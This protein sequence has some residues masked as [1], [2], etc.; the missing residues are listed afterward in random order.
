MRQSRTGFVVRNAHA[1]NATAQ[2]HHAP[3]WRRRGVIIGTLLGAI[4]VG[5]ARNGLAIAQFQ[6]GDLSIKFD[7]LWQNFTIGLLV[8]VAVT[9]DQWIRRV[10]S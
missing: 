2:I 1:A 10:S 7:P 3:G 6:I 9:L 8:I 4:I 5:M